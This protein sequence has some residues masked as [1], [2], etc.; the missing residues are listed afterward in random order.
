ME[1]QEELKKQQKILKKDKIVDEGTDFSAAI[2]PIIF[3]ANKC[4]DGYEG[5]ILG[6]FY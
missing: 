2:P 3:L 6:D 1:R 4:E 5:D